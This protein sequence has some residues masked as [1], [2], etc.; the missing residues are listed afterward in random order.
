MKRFHLF[1]FEDLA[2][3]PSLLRNY[4]TDFLRTVSEKFGMFDPVIPH[5]VS[6]V[7]KHRTPR[8][9]DLASGAGGQWRTLLAKVLDKNQ[10]IQLTLTD[11]FPN[12]ASL[13]YIA[14]EFG[15]SV[16]I[17]LRSI[18]VMDVPRD[19][20][21]VRTMFLSLHHFRPQDVERILINAVDAKA[22]I[23]IF[24]AQRRDV[25]HIIRFSLSP[26]A[27]LLLTPFIRPF[28][29][30]RLL[31]T[32]L[33]PV[34]PLVVLWDG[35]VSVLRTYTNEELERMAEFIDPGNC[36]TWSSELI[37]NGQQK[38]Q[39]FIGFPGNQIEEGGSVNSENPDPCRLSHKAMQE[40]TEPGT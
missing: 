16:E 20:I 38:I 27:V 6:L 39:V 40:N 18:D 7:E 10:D 12:R 21:G 30:L 35:V 2:W 23:A 11:K 26:I 13:E 24:E 14:N 3:F 37:V 33:I 28:S 19:L 9:V 32:Y 8:I 29:V 15:D 5:L 4:V 1:E 22:P 17:D 25:E 34:V 31:F 36:F